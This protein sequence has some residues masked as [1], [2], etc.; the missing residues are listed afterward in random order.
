MLASSASAASSFVYRTDLPAAT[1]WGAWGVT[2]L[3][4]WN[5]DVQ[6]AVSCIRTRTGFGTST[7]VGH[8]PSQGRAV[9]IRPNSRAN[10]TKLANWVLATMRNGNPL[11]IQYEVASAQIYDIARASDGVR[12]MANRGGV[13]QNHQDHVHV[14]FITPG[15]IHVNCAAVP[16]FGSTTA[17]PAPA[18]TS[19]VSRLWAGAPT[20]QQGSSGQYVKD[21]QHFLNRWHGSKRVKL[22]EDG[23]YGPLT[24]AAEMVFEQQSIGWPWYVN[25]A[26]RGVTADGR[27]QAAEQR[28]ARD[29]LVFFRV[30]WP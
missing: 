8:D 27:A 1:S 19:S 16:A 30:V 6:P 4:T 10:H 5:A 28:W 7:Y 14:S 24:A 23:Q 29:F 20:L 9:D 26:G 18:V 17:G 21:W 25:R 12:L 22:A 15:P 11:G 3:S 13:T 2:A